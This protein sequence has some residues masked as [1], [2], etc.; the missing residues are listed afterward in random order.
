[1][2]ALKKRNMMA[3]YDGF[4]GPQTVAHV[5]RIMGDIPGLTGR[6][7]GLVMSAINR[8]YHEGRASTGAEM[9]DSNVVWVN[10]INRAIEIKEVG[11]EYED[12]IEIVES[13]YGPPTKIHSKVKVKAGEL[14]AE[15]Q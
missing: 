9:I 11:A 7:I 8:A 1:M 14:V 4:K 2:N 10:N 5:H 3:N 13:S 12:K 15:L 6:Q